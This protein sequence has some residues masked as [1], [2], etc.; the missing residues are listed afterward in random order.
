M[1]GQGVSVCSCGVCGKRGIVGLNLPLSSIFSFSS[2]GT[3][4]RRGPGKSEEPEESSTET[5]PNG[6]KES[7]T[8]YIVNEIF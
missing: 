4:S 2:K 7:K 3:E 6:S 1:K 5:K 8:S